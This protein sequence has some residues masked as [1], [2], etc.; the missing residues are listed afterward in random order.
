M[1]N[2]YWNKFIDRA[3]KCTKASTNV[4]Y[5]PFIGSQ[6][7]DSK[8]KI[9]VLG[10][11]HYG[12]KFS[13]IRENLLLEGGANR[14]NLIATLTIDVV[15]GSFLWKNWKFRYESAMNFPY[16]I[17]IN[18][19]LDDDTG[20]QT[21]GFRK[22]FQR[23][24]NLIRGVQSRN[25]CSN[26]IWNHLAFYNYFQRI[27]G[28]KS[29]DHKW[30]TDEL[31]NQS[32][33]ALIEIL[34][35][36]KPDIVIVWGQFQKKWRLDEVKQAN[37]GIRFHH[38]M[39]PSC[40]TTKQVLGWE[41]SYSRIK[42]DWNAFLK[43]NNFIISDILKKHPYYDTTRTLY[44]KIKEKTF[45]SNFICHLSQ[46]CLTFELFAQKKY[47]KQKKTLVFDNSRSNGIFLDII[48]DNAGKV[49]I[50]FYMSDHSTQRAYVFSKLT[51]L[52]TNIGLKNIQDSINGHF[53]VKSFPSETSISIV[54]DTA[55]PI[56]E[57]MLKARNILA[58]MSIT[59]LN[60]LLKY[61]EKFYSIKKQG[62]VIGNIFNF[63][64]TSNSIICELFLTK[65]I[66]PKR[67]PAF[68]KTNN[69]MYFEIILN[70]QNQVTCNLYTKNRS[71]CKARNI[72]LHRD[73]FN[74]K[75]DILYNHSNTDKIYD[76]MKSGALNSYCLLDILTFME[77][78]VEFREKYS[79]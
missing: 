33:D 4:N 42:N 63:Y 40:R 71:V 38:I 1:N 36:L 28:E 20:D 73:F 31:I 39:H 51:G 55:V 64:Q 44:H 30:V 26:Y 21:L 48:Y 58:T 37:K 7:F 19:D 57:D 77:T 13:K 27:V 59:N 17:D 67:P 8:C 41:N 14:S 23:T 53:L 66:Y 52:N 18:N 9:L 10:E 29:Q 35:A 25:R 54:V 79:D 12:S 46:N 5:L 68:I 74:V 70:A 22:N 56:L 45:L 2:D 76:V 72:L 65:K 75:D 11:S 3:Q 49:E 78:M 15:L 32:K 24:A 47:N 62:K 61:L 60:F 34:S 69:A 6:Y 50:R 43:T 16:P